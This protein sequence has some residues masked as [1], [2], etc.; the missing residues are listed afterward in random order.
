[1][2][3]ALWR[4][5]T[6]LTKALRFSVISLSL[7]VLLELVFFSLVAGN[8]AG[9]L[10]GSAAN[11]EWLHPEKL[12]P[13]RHYDEL[14]QR[15]LFSPDRKP[16]ESAQQTTKT[17]NGKASDHWLLAGVIKSA[18]QSYVMFSEKNGQSRLK[19]ELGMLLDGWKVETIRSDQVVLLKNGASDTLHLLVSEPKKKP[20]RVVRK[21]ARSSTRQRTN[22][23]PNTRAI[24]RQLKSAAK[25]EAES[26]Q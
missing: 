3:S 12:A 16:K 11:F 17:A 23:A 1:M 21:K 8:S 9:E 26:S 24:Q 18:E 20:K 6:P 19:L 13:Q 22:S 15:A 14:V 2:S 5:T 10:A 25:I 7:L 4:A